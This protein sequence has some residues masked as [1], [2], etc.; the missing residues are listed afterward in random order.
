[1]GAVAGGASGKMLFEGEAFS[2]HHI[3]PICHAAETHVSEV[4]A[5]LLV[6]GHVRG[7]GGD[8][9]YRWWGRCN[10]HH[11]APAAVGLDFKPAIRCLHAHPLLVVVNKITAG[12]VHGE[13][14]CR[15]GHG[16]LSAVGVAR[17]S[18]ASQL[19]AL[20][21]CLPAVRLGGLGIEV[22]TYRGFRLVLQ[23]LLVS[24]EVLRQAIDGIPR[25]LKLQYPEIILQ[26]L[27][28]PRYCQLL[29]A[30]VRCT[31]KE[32]RTAVYL[33]QG[34]DVSHTQLVARDVASEADLVLVLGRDEAVP[35][36]NMDVGGIKEGVR[37]K[38][39]AEGLLAKAVFLLYFG[40]RGRLGGIAVPV[41]VKPDDGVVSE[42]LTSIEIRFA[43]GQ[44]LL[45]EE[46]GE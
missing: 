37:T 22:N 11:L 46:V 28:P 18:E 13:V 1:M 23:H 4:K 3:Q 21:H 29:S 6:L 45:C 5:Q 26:P 25:H 7:D 9:N 12:A 19:Q 35:G 41:S 32:V 43:P 42:I 38:D 20:F 39:A 36:G 34:L 27:A 10:S 16:H 8:I 2:W 30:G 40:G 44:L 17:L 15:E 14:V 24:P 31:V 33:Q